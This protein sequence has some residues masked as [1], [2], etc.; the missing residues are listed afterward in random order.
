MK[1]LNTMTSNYVSVRN[2]MIYISIVNSFAIE[3]NGVC[4]YV[5]VCEV[6]L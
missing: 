3:L 4:V 5:C 6:Q 1:M 2:R